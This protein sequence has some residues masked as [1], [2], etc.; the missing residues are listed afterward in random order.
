MAKVSALFILPI[1]MFNFIRKS[2]AFYQSATI[3][4]LVVHLAVKQQSLAVLFV[5]FGI[6]KKNVCL[7]L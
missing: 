2:F 4:F 5:S 3:Y 6:T 7:L 1:L